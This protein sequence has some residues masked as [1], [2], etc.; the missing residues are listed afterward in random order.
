MNDKYIIESISNATGVTYSEE[1]LKIL[2]HRGGMCIIACAG[3]GKALDNDTNILTL[4][5][6]KRIADL[7]IGDI[8]FDEKGKQQKVMGVY[9]QGEKEAYKVT[10]VDGNSIICCGEH[11]WQYRTVDNKEWRVKTLNEMVVNEDFETIEDKSGL[12]YFNLY[13]PFHNAVDFGNT[14][15]STLTEEKIDPY[16]VGKYIG[17]FYNI[18][19]KEFTSIID[20]KEMVKGLLS[21]NGVEKTEHGW[22]V[23][24]SYKSTYSDIKYICN[25]LGLMVTKEKRVF[26][27]EEN[28]ENLV[29]EI[30]DVNDFMTNGKTEKRYLVDEDNGIKCY[31]DNSLGKAI[32]SVERT[33]PREMTCIKVSGESE[34]FIADHG[35]V[36][37]N[38]TILTHLLAK[39][40]LSGEIPD[41]SR[42]LCT[43]YS[44]AGSTE[45]E[46]RLK[47][48]FTKLGIRSSI[49]V[50]TMHATYYNVLKAFGKEPRVCSAGQRSAFIAKAARDAGAPMEE[51]DLQTLDSLL[52][53][54]VNNMLN[55][56]ELTKSYVYTLELEPQKFSEIRRGY[57]ER[58]QMEGLIDF[59]DMQMYMYMLLCV[60]KD[61]NVI[62]YCR[63]KWDY[64][65]VDEFQDISKI[66]FEIL[67]ALVTD[68]NKLIVI[69]DDDQCLVGGTLVETM[70]G[71][72][73]IE[74]VHEGDLLKTSEGS[75]GIKYR[76]VEK[77]S[78][79][80]I[81]DEIIEIKT[82]TSRVLKGTQD[83]VM[84]A[85]EQVTGETYNNYIPV[86][87]GFH[88]AHDTL[89]FRLNGEA[90]ITATIISNHFENIMGKYGKVMYVNDMKKV[91]LEGTSDEMEH[92]LKYIL[93]DCR[94]NCVNIKLE[95]TARVNKKVYNFIEMGKIRVGMLIP[96]VNEKGETTEEVVTSVRAEH[97]K[98]N[99][100][101]VT[102]EKTRNF[103]ANGIVV[104]NCI[105][106]WRG[107][108]PSI[109]LN[110]CGYYDI[111][112]FILS[113]NY[114][115][116]GEI[117]NHAAQCIKN[118]TRRAEK[119]MMPFNDGGR[120]RLHE[121]DSGDIL[122]M[123]RIAYNYIEKLIEK[124]EEPTNI[125]V[126]SRNNNHLA[127]L[128]DMLLLG[129]FMY[130]SQSEMKFTHLPMYKDIRNII[131][132]MQDTYN[133]SIVKKALW[134]I[135]QYLGARGANIIAEV[136][137]VTGCSVSMAIGY[138]LANYTSK[139]KEIQ[140]EGKLRLPT[141]VH[142]KLSYRF[143]A[144][145]ADS[146][147][148][149]VTIYKYITEEKLESHFGGVMYLYEEAVDFMYKSHDRRRSLYGI[150]EYIE[151]L[152]EEM[153]LSRTIEH[154]NITERFESGKVS[155][156]GP[157][158]TMSTMHGAKGKEWKYVILFANDN[159]SCPAFQGIQKMIDDNIDYKD[160]NGSIDENRRLAYVAM[161][162]AKEELLIIGSSKN[163][164]CYT[165]EAMGLLKQ[166]N[167][168][169]N[170]A[171]IIQF[172]KDGELPA[173][174]R[175]EI[176]KL[177]EEG[178]PYYMESLLKDNK[179]DKE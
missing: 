26:N 35:V 8:V 76:R 79:R 111:Q 129:G 112:R 128:S 123:S 127:I 33:K 78:C 21:N 100:Y 101:D 31:A 42:L 12:H 176:H 63:N 23:L 32:I 38:T 49:Q 158:V 67:K 131:E 170:N 71:K 147:A 114:R 102:I 174:L 120:I 10:F 162:R 115:C 2:Q 34:L 130:E 14:P 108:D 87:D 91:F 134:R 75:E 70:S 92:T 59:D 165:L 62:N 3:S 94:K 142:D 122:Q 19:G 11:L 37:H 16:L 44:K 73:A 39:R 82:S 17:N 81:N 15:F 88:E 57:N 90:N 177:Y 151:G 179:T 9:P 51:E 145:G 20:R 93:E 136:M 50:K 45:M 41:T 138:C 52:S 30:I 58:K 18:K 80:E 116:G 60:Y 66:Q 47:A 1:Q 46:E 72:K 64:F 27:H 154:L 104:H 171:K 126:L 133:V 109:I 113:T 161:T 25:S 119:Q 22:R 167:P 89:T 166:N 146:I 137:T 155:S 54:Q 29:F 153:G 5:G 84:F 36:T 28:K 96:V 65:F 7:S 40:I 83:H 95:K 6:Y 148:R 4:S 43:T 55:D 77:V 132:I 168:G 69:G 178:S 74:N 173:D 149:L 61:Q 160:I 103:V 13:I 169:D 107:A 143:R 118:N 152:V 117:I 98:G 110:I 106:Q 105:Y 135:C 68:E 175:M 24:V 125:A 163:L 86:G 140:W 48:L 121:C 53:Y 124:G 99:V 56:E 157:K 97:Y 164:S 159:I 141:V 150:T 172:A 139:G 85:R 144:I 156:L